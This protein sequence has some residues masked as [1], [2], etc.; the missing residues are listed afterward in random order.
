MTKQDALKAPC[1]YQPGK[2]C[3][4]DGCPKWRW[5]SFVACSA[6]N[7]GFAEINQ[8]ENIVIDCICDNANVQ[9]GLKWNRD[10]Y[11]NQ[12]CIYKCHYRQ[13]YCQ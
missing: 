8:Q 4:A 2:L 10:K 11:N 7:M 3:I 1:P 6:E 9:D 5:E 13:G 12:F